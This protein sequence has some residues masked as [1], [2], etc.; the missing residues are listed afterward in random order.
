VTLEEALSLYRIDSIDSATRL[1]GIIGDPV[2]H[3]LSPLI[4]NA[5]YTALGMNWRYLPFQA[6]TM[7]GVPD[8]VRGLGLRGLSVTAPHKVAVAEHL[9]G[10]EPLARRLG[11]VNTVV[12]DG[13]RLF[14][15]NTDVEGVTRP[16]R[17]RM[18]PSGLVALVLGAGGAGRAAGAAVATLGARIVIA[19]RRRRPGMAVARMLGG[20]WIP[21]DRA[22]REP[23]AILIN[24]TSV[25]AS[26]RGM[27]V[28]R[29]ALSG[30]L[31]GDLIYRAGG[32]PL[33]RAARE[34]GI[35]AF[36]GE[37]VLL[38]QA[39]SQFS[40]FTGREAPEVLMGGALSLAVRG[41]K[42]GYR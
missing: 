7:R 14:G 42:P 31:V 33:V 13:R 36:G 12:S 28:P 11:A 19:S 6:R 9:S 26:G 37:E 30:T 1:T 41:R 5:A 39:A 29:R 8:L 10:A 35:P 23:H 18:D 15:F 20:R 22:A 25:G 17:A 27:P 4:H 24:A 3:S 34:K 32:T 38:A 21:F 40:L 2:S 16:V